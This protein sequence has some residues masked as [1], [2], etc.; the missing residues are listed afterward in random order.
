MPSLKDLSKKEELISSGHRLCPGC[1]ASIIVRQVLLTADTPVVV[2]SPTGCL[3]VS[4]TIYPFTAWK[5]PFIHNAFENAAA[6]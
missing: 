1:G 3:E 2:C 4:T 5:I 6:T